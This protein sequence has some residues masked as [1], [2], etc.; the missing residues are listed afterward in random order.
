MFHDM[1]LLDSVNACSNDVINF[2]N[3]VLDEEAEEKESDV[4][5]INEVMRDPYYHRYVSYNLLQLSS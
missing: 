4:D 1:S 2:I 5:E 3:S